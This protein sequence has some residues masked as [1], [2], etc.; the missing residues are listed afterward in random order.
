MLALKL[1]TN[2]IDRKII[3]L[4]LLWSPEGEIPMNTRNTMVRV[5]VMLQ[6]GK[7]EPV[8]EPA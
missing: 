5:E 1:A 6:Y 8:P 4:T 2:E 7:M 3:V